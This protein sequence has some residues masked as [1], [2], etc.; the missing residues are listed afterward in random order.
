M[1]EVMIRSLHLFVYPCLCSS[2]ALFEKGMKIPPN[3]FFPNTCTVEIEF[4]KNLF[5]NLSDN[6]WPFPD[7]RCRPTGSL[8]LI[9]CA[10]RSL[11]VY[12]WTSAE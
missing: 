1:A 5:V 3:L 10:V 8:R 2:Y 11:H 9:D 4:S 6:N 12:S 7:I